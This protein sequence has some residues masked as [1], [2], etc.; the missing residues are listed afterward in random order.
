MS[1]YRKLIGQGSEATTVIG[2]QVQHMFKNWDAQQ[3]RSSGD[4]AA[5]MYSMESLSETRRQELANLDS[6]LNTELT[7]MEGLADQ[8][9]PTPAGIEASKIAGILSG[10]PSRFLKQDVTRPLSSVSMEGHD[11]TVVQQHGLG[12]TVDSRAV[13]M[14]AYDQTELRNLTVYSKVYN[15]RAGNQDEFSGGFFRAVT[16]PPDEAGYAVSIN[17]VRVMNETK[18][19]VSGKAFDPGFK[20][21]IHALIHD[22]II[23]ND[24][25]KLIPIVR[26]DSE[27]SFY[28]VT[29]MVPQMIKHDG[30]DIATSGLAFNKQVDLLGLSQTAATLAVGPMN[31]TDAIDSGLTLDAL[32]MKV[33]TGAGAE[34]IKLNTFGLPESNF[35]AP[36]QGD[37]RDMIL[38]FDSESVGLL[39]KIVTYTGAD[40][41]HLKP[42]LDDD[43]VV[44]LKLTVNGRVNTFT[45]SISL[46]N[47]PVGIASVFDSATGNYLAAGNPKYDQVVTLLQDAALV[48]WTVDGYR[49]NSNLRTRGQLLDTTY[50]TQIYQPKLRSPITVARPQ[51]AQEVAD[52]TDIASLLTATGIMTTNEGVAALF[53]TATILRNH[54]SRNEPIDSM[55]TVL[56]IAHGP[57]RAVYEYEAIDVKERIN[58]LATHQ[59]AVDAQ[60]VLINAVRD[61][62]F[63]AYVK[64]GYKPCADALHGGRA[65]KPKVLIGTD[66]EIAG[67][68]M[69]HGDSRTLGAEFDYEVVS[70]VNA[71]MAGKIFVTF[72]SG[73]EENGRPDPLT[74]GNMAWKP[75]LVVALPLH[76]QGENSKQIMVSPC[77]THVVNLPILMEFDVTNLGEATNIR[78]PI[79]VT[80]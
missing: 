4:F 31:Q 24:Q 58:S 64:S 47:G 49:T 26:T 2:A 65:P 43:L 75:E 23:R 60:H 36:P 71:R 73:N 50:R 21:I 18:R 46:S 35:F 67:W 33:G 57:V 77:F 76:F 12:Y 53:R 34:I 45:G 69:I 5:G 28:D 27:S 41:V 52:A 51:T 17:I 74:F 13:S 66:P 56:G 55:P 25:T 54:V 15:L 62:V 30:E 7:S 19:E 61:A 8:F 10:D 29:E 78:T 32:Y 40:S 22:H 14:E 11:A 39:N 38:S 42:I 16:V 9:K 44:R 63:K 20:N 59:K 48:A 6:Q 3:Y 72:V 80:P 37:Y 1:N 68:F 70:T 79:E